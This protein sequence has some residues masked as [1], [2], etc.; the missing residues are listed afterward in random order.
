MLAIFHP[1]F[2]FPLV[3]CAPC[4]FRLEWIILS[5]ER[6]KIIIQF[7]SLD[8]IVRN[9]C[10]AATVHE[11]YLC[12]QALFCS[13]RRLRIASLSAAN[14]QSNNE[15]VSRSFLIIIRFVRNRARSSL[16]Q[17]D[18]KIATGITRKQNQVAHR[19][20]ARQN[21]NVNDME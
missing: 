19:I 6:S 9:R 15:D 2:T 14:F 13:L 3:Q 17:Y 20:Q 16:K 1:V 8:F 4:I 11:Q 7:S 12:R 10:E 21:G 18:G 5:S